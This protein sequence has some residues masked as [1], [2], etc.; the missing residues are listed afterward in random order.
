MKRRAG[1]RMAALFGLNALVALVV[2]VLGDRDPHGPT[3]PLRRRALIAFN[4]FCNA[5]ALAFMGLAVP[6]VALGGLGFAAAFPE[7]A[8]LPRYQKALGWASWLMPMSWPITL[9]GAYALLVQLAGAAVSLNR[10]DR[11]RVH[12][13]FVDAATG[14]VVLEGGWLYRPGFKG[15]YNLGN[16]AFITPGAH[17]IVPHETGHTLSVA[18]LGGAFHAAGAIDENLLKH[19]RR[20]EAYA[21]RIAESHR[22]DREG[23]IPVWG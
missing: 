20:R 21:E 22:S 14:T 18:A 19:G 9:L 4:A 11:F 2:Y 10:V 5:F 3:E 12:R 8:R 6:G 23:T 7:T 17:R 1:R 15:G 13:I 16:F